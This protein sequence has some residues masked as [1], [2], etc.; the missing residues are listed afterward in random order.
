MSG[1][2]LRLNAI[3]DDYKKVFPLNNIPKKRPPQT[4]IFQGTKDHW[5]SGETGP[6]II[7]WWLKKWKS[8]CDFK[9]IWKGRHGFFQS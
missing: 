7:K 6:S 1:G 2:L 8:R 9:I 4:I 3:G 5:Y